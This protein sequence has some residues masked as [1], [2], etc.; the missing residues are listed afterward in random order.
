MDYSHGVLSAEDLDLI[1]SLTFEQQPTLS[2]DVL[3]DYCDSLPINSAL[4]HQSDSRGRP[5]P[6]STAQQMRP[7]DEEFSLPHTNSPDFSLDFG[8]IRTPQ[9]YAPQYNLRHQ[10][11]DHHSTGDRFL[12]PT[13]DNKLSLPWINPPNHSPGPNHTKTHQRNSHYQ[14]EQHHPTEYPISVDSM[15]PRSTVHARTQHP[16]NAESRSGSANS[17]YAS[18]AS[19]AIVAPHPTTA[20]PTPEVGGLR[21]DSYASAIAT[22]DP[23]FRDQVK[24]KAINDD[25][26]EVEQNG[27]QYVPLIVDALNYDSW[28]DAE[29]FRLNM[30]G[31]KIPSTAFD[32]KDW[33]EWQAETFEVVKGHFTMPNIEARVELIAWAILEEILDVHR[34]GFR[35]TTLTANRKSKCSQRVM[36]V[37]KSIKS[38]AMA[39]QR[40][41]EGGDLS[42]LAAGPKAYAKGTA[43]NRRNNR[44]RKAKAQA[45]GGSNVSGGNAQTRAKKRSPKAMG[46][47]AKRYMSRAEV[48]RRNREDKD[49]S[50]DEDEDEDEDGDEDEDEEEVGTFMAGTQPAQRPAAPPA[51]MPSYEDLWAPP[52]Q[53]TQSG[54]QRLPNIPRIDTDRIAIFGESSDSAVQ[55]PLPSYGVRDGAVQFEDYG[56]STVPHLNTGRIDYHGG[57]STSAMRST[58]HR[59]TNHGV[60]AGAYASDFTFQSPIN[61]LAFA[62][63]QESYGTYHQGQR[64]RSAETGGYTAMIEAGPMQFSQLPGGMFE[65]SSDEPGSKR[66]RSD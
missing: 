36:L 48:A 15:P 33:E 63:Q 65:E 43:T 53:P 6:V 9:Y 49:D 62:H 3:T 64:R 23:L 25:H 17:G 40:I 28:M 24:V 26:F 14:P 29:E 21:F 55:S 44:G 37:V 46:A 41:L 56:F 12:T 47:I 18:P 38:T 7:F 66:R 30:T 34:K 45:I 58:L 39:R 20:I 51:S 8:H 52:S 13:C 50:E 10:P 16:M 59:G 11:E 22:V 19:A 54:A 60:N 61:G 31:V 42:D 1:R 4:A 32:I 27:T 57:S 35:Y 5:R 2:P